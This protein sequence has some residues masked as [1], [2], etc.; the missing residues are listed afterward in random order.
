MEINRAVDHSRRFSRGEGA[1]GIRHGPTA[2]RFLS[3]AGEQQPRLLAAANEAANLTDKLPLAIPPPA[4]AMTAPHC[5]KLPHESKLPVN[6]GELPRR[7][8][9]PL[10]CRMPVHKIHAAE[11][12][13]EIMFHAGFCGAANHV[14]NA[15]RCWTGLPASSFF[16]GGIEIQPGPRQRS[17][18][19]F[20]VR[21][22]PVRRFRPF[23][24]REIAF[25]H[26]VRRAAR[27]DF[28]RKTL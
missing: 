25:A 17:L 14:M 4:T 12:P 16:E 6:L 5:Q 2:N 18:S 15:T 23:L 8:L 3:L 9:L 22:F 27:V 19:Q 1:P 10:Q 24:D 11:Q 21:Q 7:R 28:L 26:R 20:G 13:V